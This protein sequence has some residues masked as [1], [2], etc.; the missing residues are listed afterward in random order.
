MDTLLVAVRDAIKNSASLAYLQGVNVIDDELLPPEEIG[1]PQVGVKD[2]DW[3]NEP[4]EFQKGTEIL[5]VRVT[6]YQSVL[7]ATPGASVMGETSLGDR[8]KGTLQIAK[9]LKT[10]LHKNKLGLSG[11]YLARLK[12]IE[13]SRTI[14]S[15]DTEHYAQM[16]SLGFEYARSVAE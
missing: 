4:K 8:G 11:Y 5:R 2:G 12:K 15:A 13:A 3:D 9:D 7:L 10:L 6:A 14:F 1:W 16:Q